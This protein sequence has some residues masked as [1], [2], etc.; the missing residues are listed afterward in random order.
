MGSL[1]EVAKAGLVQKL[2]GESM[3]IDQKKADKYEAELKRNRFEL[4]DEQITEGKDVLATFVKAKEA[5]ERIY[6]AFR[7]NGWM[8]RL[9][10]NPA[11]AFQ[12]AE[13]IMAEGA[14]MGW[15]SIDSV[16]GVSV[17]KVR[18]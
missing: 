1:L 4:S 7:S 14:K 16:D 13:T 3:A 18:H 2:T 11:V 5:D 9:A 15:Y 6:I 12:L 8:D 17:P 10:L